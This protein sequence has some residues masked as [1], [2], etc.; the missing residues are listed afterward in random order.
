M[1]YV[2]ESSLSSELQ[3]L[4]HENVTLLIITYYYL[5]HKKK[6]FLRLCLVAMATKLP[7]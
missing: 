5:L 7:W 3:K 1:D 6:E 4:Q 2:I